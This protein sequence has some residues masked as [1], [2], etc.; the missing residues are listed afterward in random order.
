[1]RP[2]LR[3]A[4]VVL[5]LASLFASSQPALSQ[6]PV[7]IVSAVSITEIGGIGSTVKAK[8]AKLNASA[9][10]KYQW[11]L[12]GAVLPGKT[13]TS[14]KL[15]SSYQ[16]KS[17]AVRETVKFGSGR[18]LKSTSQPFLVGVL[19]TFGSMSIDFSDGTKTAL[20]AILP[21]TT[22]QATS[23]GYAW[24]VSPDF[25]VN[26]TNQEFTLQDSYYGKT[27][28]VTVTMNRTGFAPLVVTSEPFSISESS[29]G[30][31]QATG[32]L[33]IGF[34]NTSP[35][36]LKAIIPATTPRATSY[37]YSWS[38][39]QDTGVTGAG[40]EF[41]ILKSY[42]GQS[43]TVTVTYNRA[44]YGSL[45]RTSNPFLIPELTTGDQVLLWSQEFDDVAASAAESKY[46]SNDIGDG[47]GVGNC[48]W[49]N[50][51]RQW[52][53]SNKGLQDGNGNFAIT[54][55]KGGSNNNC[56]YGGKCEWESAK[57]TTKGKI[58]FKYG[59]VEARIKGA[60][61]Q[62]PWPAFWMLGANYR[63]VPGQ[64]TDWPFCGEIDI[65]EAIGANPNY[66]Y[67]TPHSPTQHSGGQGYTGGNSLAYHNYAIDWSE[68][69]IAWL[70]DGVQFYQITKDVDYA[71]AFYPF[72]Q[73]FYVIVNMAIG[74]GFGGSVDPSLTSATMNIDWIRYYSV[75]GVGQ[76][77]NH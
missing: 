2:R 13:K 5:L 68:N 28:S 8:P 62:G 42:Y 74:G 70:I 44:G 23:F 69:K 21:A 60:A 4:A 12:N 7:K 58:G 47:C 38:L 3:F 76:V 61:G 48:G 30:T 40:Q 64:S 41:A 9:S 34:S 22:P 19:Q 39:S 49:G 55:T 67:G 71:N 37:S 63:E 57:L 52:Y 75:G 33:R 17:L 59:R 45:T 31:L 66:N 11:L 20:R 16:N 14:I 25:G 53:T 73:E 35:S 29:L 18:V 43:A 54:A 51:E 27:V 50:G 24:K 77:F 15:I 46:W 6:P 1:M 56:Y 36:T 26:G 32:Q 65:F 72:N 10:R